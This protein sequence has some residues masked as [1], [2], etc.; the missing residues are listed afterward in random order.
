MSEPTPHAEGA[1]HVNYVKIW[2]ILLVLLVVSITGPFV[3]QATGLFIITLITAFG[4]AF[5]KAYLVAKNFMHLNMER[6]VIHYALAAALAIMVLFFA[7]VSPDV[8]NHEGR[9]WVNTAAKAETERREAIGHFEPGHGA[10]HEGAAHEGAAHEAAPA[11]EATGEA[12]PA[13]H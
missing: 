12:A 3:G 9:R 1:H 13:A 4:I 10:A 2:A 5:V 8:M 11:G 6:P 7:A